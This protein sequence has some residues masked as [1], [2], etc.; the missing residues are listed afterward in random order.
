[1]DK[2]EIKIRS[3]YE[4]DKTVLLEKRV[5]LLED[6]IL[7]IKNAAPYQTTSSSIMSP[8]Y[9]S[10][11]DGW[12]IDEN[13]DVEF[14]SGTFSGA[15]SASTIDIGGSDSTSFHVDIN[16][17]M[18]LGAATFDSAPAKISSNGDA[19]FSSINITGGVI[20]GTSTIA[21]ITGTQISYVAT[22][23]ADS[24]PTGLTYSTGGISTGSDG[25]QSAYVVLT[26]NAISSNTFD[27]YLVRYKKAA[28]TYYTYIPAT[29]NTITI[30]GL[31]PN[32]S[33]NFGVCSVNKY[34]TSS[35]FSSDI[36]QTTPSDSTAPATVTGV[37]ATAGIQYVIVQWTHNTESDLASY[38]IYRNTTNNSETATLIGNCRTNYF[39]D[40]GRTG[41]QIY[42][43]WVKAVDT[44]GNVSASFSTVASATPRNVVSSDTN[45]ASQGWTQTCVFSST[46][47]DTVSWGAGT[48]TTAAGTSYSIS[49]GNTGNMTAITY[50][51]L[52]I[53]VSTTAY[54][55]TT[56]A[57]NAVGDG[58][59]LIAVAQ[60][61]TT[62]ATF[63]V[64]GGSG[65]VAITGGDIENRSITN[66]QIAAA[67][68]TSNEIAANTIVAGNIH[69]GTITSN[70]IAT[71]TITSDNILS[72]AGS[73]VLIDGTTYLSNWRKTGDL[74]KIDGGQISTNTVTLSQLNFTPVQ[75]T[76]VI[77]SINASTEGIKID[78]D[79]ITISGAT[80]FDSGYDPTTKTAKVGGTYDSASSGARVRIFPDTNT[81]IQVIDNAGD[82]VF[83]AMVGGTD[84]GDVIMGNETTGNYAKW[85]NSAGILE[86]FA[87]N[88]PTLGKATF[89]GNGSDG[90]LSIT[91]GTT[92][93]DL[94]GAEYFEKNY[95][96]I[97][98][99]GTGALTFSNPHNNGTKI[100]LKSKGNVTI[101][102]SATRAID[103][104]NLGGKGGASSTGNGNEGLA[105]RDMLDTA[106][107]AGRGGVGGTSGG[108]VVGAGG[109]QFSISGLY[110]FKASRNYRK[111]VE[112][113][114]GPGGG[115]GSG[116]TNAPSGAGGRGGGALLIECNDS[117]NI[118]GTIDASGGNG[119][120]GTS[121]WGEA[122]GGGGGGA[123]GHILIL[124]R[125][126]TANTG[127]YIVTG[128]NGGD[129]GTIGSSWG[130]TGGGGGG[131]LNGKGGNGGYVG[132]GAAQN[133]SSGLTG[134]SGGTAGANNQ[135]GGGGGGAAGEFLV[136]ENNLIA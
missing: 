86:V 55:I 113:T 126:L 100:V 98:I 44:S 23:T 40:G 110:P 48:F 39:I 90:A 35:A 49:A 53:A 111:F 132:S 116:S 125:T 6:Q 91:S 130:G 43:Y 70:E 5:S 20:D 121:A 14:N 45:I 117:L 114:S 122:S 78:A 51:Y 56:T 19:T 124:Y 63:Q 115:S 1:M 106:L 18:W 27:H 127:T 71:N 81:G 85:D 16:G 4:E 28:L 102:S 77:A 12:K 41:G 80:T 88:V 66:A 109:V 89:G 75:T 120:N 134:G 104:R 123:G 32:V 21:G 74:T 62:E 61:S 65:G 36:I 59:V 9:K 22:S 92:N 108:A 79:N 96:S 82:N 133:G 99:S 31:T 67:T 72:I 38:N 57:T 112:F 107:V 8:N 52:D 118:T 29:T 47:A 97:T 50:I 60:K 135:A 76:N 34:G 24:V 17:N 25:S 83:K 84:V 10:G 95:T 42:Y 3:I 33:Y 58:K 93:I 46:D 15:L 128:G 101:T 129:G 87:D 68:I 37:S 69:A 94:G 64:F 13:G 26:W 131:G 73:K 11:S 7:N 2:D 136:A 54:Q 30:E 103:L 119:A 105:H